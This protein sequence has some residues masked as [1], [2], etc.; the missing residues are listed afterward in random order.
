MPSPANFTPNWATRARYWG[1]SA[2][3][4]PARLRSGE[5][6]VLHAPAAHA[7]DLEH[8]VLLDDWLDVAARRTIDAESID[9][10]RTWTERHDEALTIGG[11]RL[12]WVHEGELS[13]TYSCGCD[14]SRSVYGPAFAGSQPRRVDLHCVDPDLATALVELLGELGVG[15]VERI[16]EAPPPRYPIAFATSIGP[17]TPFVTAAHQFTGLPAVVRGQVLVKP[18]RHVEPLWEPLLERPGAHPVVDPFDLPDLPPSLLGRIVMGGGWIGQAGARRR[19]RS[20]RSLSKALDRLVFDP[21][22]PPFERAADRHAI[23]LLRQRAQDTLANVE[24]LCSSFSKTRLR[25]ALLPSDGTAAGRTVITAASG[26]GVRTVQAQH[27]FFADIW[28]GTD[29]RIAPFVDGLTA[30]RAAVW[31]EQQARL[32]TGATRGR[33]KV[34]GN[35]NAERLATGDW[36]DHRPKGLGHAVL[37]VQPPVGSSAL[38]D[39]RAPIRHARAALA[40]L[41]EA[42]CR[43]VVLRPHP[44]DPCGYEERPDQGVAARAGSRAGWA[45]PVR[46]RGRRRL[47]LLH[48]HGH[49][50]GRGSGGADRVPRVAGSACAVAARRVGCLPDRAHV[51]RKELRLPS[52]TPST[53]ARPR[54]TGGAR[55]CRRNGGRGD[56]FLSFALDD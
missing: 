18:Y 38:V 11:V 4:D 42:G 29:G 1:D 32:L 3:L 13:R 14:E 10:L 40:G 49:P 27:G 5:D 36:I 12:G 24:A 37:I 46:S 6:L 39:G 51:R 26:T 43:S 9:A 25:A 21:T 8:G 34:T 28:R 53:A 2:G 52:P 35:P 50:R 44:L 55:G 23:E 54:P 19:R 15:S 47:R 30:D 45:D 7:S 33:V 20:R 41:A 31:S 48:I 17:R 56:R 16:G 22:T